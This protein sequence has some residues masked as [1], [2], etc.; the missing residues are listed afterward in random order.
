MSTYRFQQAVWLATGFGYRFFRHTAQ[1]RV[2][3]GLVDL[4][5]WY[6]V[7]TVYV[8]RLCTAVLEPRTASSISRAAGGSFFILTCSSPYRHDFTDG[9]AHYVSRCVFCSC[10][11]SLK[12]TSARFWREKK[13][14]FPA[15]ESPPHHPSWR[16]LQTETIKGGEC[17][18]ETRQYEDIMRSTVPNSSS[19][20]PCFPNEHCVV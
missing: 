9:T 18:G 11:A 17:E 16:L 13:N 7:H 4:L 12:T 19:S 15:I 10:F 14:D 1:V 8:V 20:A 3:Y 5:C 6:A 2:A